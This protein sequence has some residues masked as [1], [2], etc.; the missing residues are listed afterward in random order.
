MQQLGLDPLDAMG[1]GTGGPDPLIWGP[2]WGIRFY[3]EGRATFDLTNPALEEAIEVIKRFYDV[4]GG[5]PAVAEFRK[6]Y[7]KWTGA[8]SGIASGTQAMQINGPWTPGSLAIVAPEKKYAYT[9]LAVP[10]KRKGKKIQST[11]GHFANL[12]K[13]SPHPDQGFE[14]ME[15]LWSD[16]ALNIIFDGTGWLTARKSYLSKVDVGKYRGLDF[17]VKS[18]TQADEMWE[19]PVNPIDGFFGEKWSAAVG[20]VL[21]GKLSSK[22]ALGE[23][24]R[25]CTEE[26][27]SRLGRK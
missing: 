4:A 11:G 23:L 15:F 22:A 1:G 7:G 2:S 13:G 17:Y 14:F 24:Q 27:Q 19:A 3:D 8:K 5:A 20:D 25:A 16:Q 18:V 21:N 9:W 26:L 6:Q 10:N 12:P